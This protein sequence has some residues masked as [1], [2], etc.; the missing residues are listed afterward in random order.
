MQPVLRLWEDFLS[1]R[2]V[3]SLPALPRMLFVV[4]GAA[5]VGTRPLGAGEAW[6]G[7]QAVTVQASEAGAT[8]WR[9][10][11]SAGAPA[12][13]KTVSSVHSREKLS[14]TL[15]TLPEGELLWRGDSVAFPP[16]GCAY[17]HRHQGPGIR[18]VIDGELRVDTGGHSHTYQ[19]GEAWYESGP[20]PVFAQA[21]ERPTRFIRVMILPRSLIG[22]SS[23]QYVNEDDKAKP[24]SQQYKVFIDAPLTRP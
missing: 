24:K 20:E 16:N 14:A 9:W 11:L 21:G 19:V 18:C 10:D 1:D 17:L 15:E 8:I 13:W 6:Q 4:R 7:E 3:L 22:K 5:I 2:G 12:A 23:I